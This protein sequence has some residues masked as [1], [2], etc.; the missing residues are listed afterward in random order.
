M[1]IEIMKMMR[2][3]LEKTNFRMSADRVRTN[4]EIS[5]DKKL[6]RRVHVIFFKS[7]KEARR[8]DTKIQTIYGNLQISFFTE[9]GT[10]RTGTAGSQ[11]Y[12]RG[13]RSRERKLTDQTRSDVK[14]LDRF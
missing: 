2:E 6:L 12:A 7:L 13:R 3:E 10:S 5:L 11:I 1:M 9:V 8:N 4:L 14:G